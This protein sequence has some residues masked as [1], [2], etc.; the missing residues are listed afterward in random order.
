MGT[1]NPAQEE[2]DARDQQEGIT[3]VELLELPPLLLRLVTRIAREGWVTAEAAAEY[4]GE[5]PASM[6]E[7]LDG[8][9]ERGYLGREERQEGWVYR[10]R[11][12]RKRGRELPE[13][14]WSALGQRVEDE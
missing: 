5:S 12:A 8:L 6:Q 13:N 10:T 4:F 9:V 1:F 11:F 14:I 2:I 7:A 3:P